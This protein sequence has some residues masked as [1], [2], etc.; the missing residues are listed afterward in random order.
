MPATS[1][2]ILKKIFDADEVFH[3]HYFDINCKYDEK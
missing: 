2:P 3:D 1:S